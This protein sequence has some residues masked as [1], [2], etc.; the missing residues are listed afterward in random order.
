MQ[1]AIKIV[2]RAL[3]GKQMVCIGG[4]VQSILILWSFLS[5]F[6]KLVLFVLIDVVLQGVKKNDNTFNRYLFLYYNINWHVFNIN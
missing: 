4:W 6:A 3:R 1:I 2:D 5:V